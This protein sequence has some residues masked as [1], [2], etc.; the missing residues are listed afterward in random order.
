MQEHE[1]PK[2]SGSA[3]PHLSNKEITSLLSDPQ[4][5]Q[6]MREQ[7]QRF[8]SSK[9][10]YIDFDEYKT[11]A[12]DPSASDRERR[13]CVALMSAMDSISHL[14]F[15]PTVP[16]ISQPI[17]EEDLRA[18][19]AIDSLP[20][21]HLDVKLDGF[22]IATRAAECAL[23]G[24]AGGTLGG[25]I[26][27]G[28]FGGLAG[29]LLGTAL[30]G[31]AG[32]LN[33][34]SEQLGHSLSDAIWDKQHND[35]LRNHVRDGIAYDLKGGQSH[36]SLVGDISQN[37]EVPAN[38]NMFQT[39]DF[40][41]TYIHNP[42]GR[43]DLIVDCEQFTA[44]VNDHF[45][46]TSSLFYLKED[47]AGYP[48]GTSVRIDRNTADSRKFQSTATILYPDGHKETR[49]FKPVSNSPLDDLFLYRKGT[50]NS[51]LH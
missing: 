17:S 16:T 44:R 42:N 29:A 13:L 11:V 30:G 50:L 37:F 4:N 26:V 28:P 3:E 9:D 34:T 33:E 19:Q 5:I 21:F 20:G 49:D 8:D 51:W 31:A 12:I 47:F 18:L 10:G 6:Y 36:L 24:F 25:T 27:G 22:D 48:K 40:T 41:E 14:H 1:I 38:P 32:A 43:T 2:L 23:L 45:N 46:S 15:D 35:A 7:F 39:A